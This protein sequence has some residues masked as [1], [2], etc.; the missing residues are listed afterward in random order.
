MQLGRMFLRCHSRKK[1]G[2]RHRYWSVVESR[3]CRGSRPVQRQVLYLGEINDSQQAAWRKTIEV[4][5]ERKSGTSNF[6]CF[7]PIAR[8]PRMKSMPCRWC[9]PACVFGVRVR[10]GIVGWDACCGINWGYQDSGTPSWDRN[11][12]R[13]HGGRCCS[14]WW[15]TACA[16]RAVSLPCIAVGSCAARWMSC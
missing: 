4:F 2:K 8:F 10:S 14:F 7:P 9:S 3:R 13:W 12:A 1:N 6:R 11:V 16:I 15:S 5:D